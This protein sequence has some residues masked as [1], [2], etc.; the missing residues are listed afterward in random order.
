MM[1]GLT[2]TGVIITAILAWL[3]AVISTRHL[4]IYL[5]TQA[6]L[7]ARSIPVKIVW[8]ILPTMYVGLRR[9]DTGFGLATISTI[10]SQHY[11]EEEDI[12]WITAYGDRMQGVIVAV[13]NKQN[14]YYTTPYPARKD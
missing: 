5:R 8:F 2:I 3:A 1:A 6:L 14:P 10:E 11:Y 4:S 13:L 12:W 9:G 7:R